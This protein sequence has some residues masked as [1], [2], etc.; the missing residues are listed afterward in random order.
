MAWLSSA[1]ESVLTREQF[2]AIAELRWRIFVNS[3]RT[4]H[5]RLELAS[6][7]MAGIGYSILGIGGTLGIAVAA[8]FIVSRDALEWLAL[9]LWFIF[10]YWQLFPVMATAFTENFDAATFLRFPL[11]YR[12]YFVLRL[13]YGSLDPTTFV[14]VLWLT[15]LALGIGAAAPRAWPWA[16]FVLAAFAAFNIA[17]SRA[18]FSWIERWLAR[19]KS[20]EILGVLFFLL[21]IGVQFISPLT[22]YYTHHYSR[23][24][25][26]AEFAY[27][28]Q[29]VAVQ[30]FLPPG[31]AAVALVGPLQGDFVLSLGSFALVSAY[32]FLFLAVLNIR[33]L[34]QYRGENLSESAAPIVARKGKQSVQASWE[35]GGLSS[36][37]SAIFEKEFHYLS[38][39]GPMIFPLLMPLVILLILR[40]SFANARHG[41]DFLQKHVEFAFPIGVAYAVLI[42]SN[43]SYNC[44]GTEGAGVQFYYM[45]PVRFRDVLLAKN[46]AQSLILALEMVLV[47]LVVAFLFEPP[48]PGMTMATVVGAV[49][50][51]LVNFGVGNLMSLYS[52]KKIDWAAFGRQRASGITALVVLGAQAATFGLAATAGAVAA[53][54]H[55]IWVA[56]LVLLLLATAAYR[57]YR[58]ELS[59]LDSFALTRRESLITEICRAS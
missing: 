50:G 44:F 34:A 1:P 33:L 17:L 54:F 23:L 22:T 58:Y 15:G 10:L 35:L 48:S 19:R 40:F 46:L 55:Q 37:V 38:R 53:Y 5:G 27:A 56:D 26:P 57:G 12:S 13:T 9:P 8:W 21:I 16:L 4:L 18:I 59:R 20:R 31:L 2:A 39:S 47:W 7:I 29:F 25:P 51:S 24:H 32:T 11:N 30:K 14:A 43:L 6:R 3:L 45:S 41:S 42:L 36:P 52:P 49:F 28:T